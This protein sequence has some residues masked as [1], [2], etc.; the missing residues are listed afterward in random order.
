MDRSV[1]GD[2][3]QPAAVHAH[4]DLVARE[5]LASS[6]EVGDPLGPEATTATV[7]VDQKVQLTLSRA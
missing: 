6:L 1:G 4:R 3:R 5:V 2:R 7:G